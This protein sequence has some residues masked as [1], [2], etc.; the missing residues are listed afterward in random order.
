MEFGFNFIGVRFVF[1][2]GYGGCDVSVEDGRGEGEIMEV[3]GF[4]G[5]L[6]YSFRREMFR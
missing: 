3:E 5:R 4:V 1:F 6:R 2:R